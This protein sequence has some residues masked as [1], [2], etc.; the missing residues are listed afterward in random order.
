M[1]KVIAFKIEI[2]GHEDSRRKIETIR[3]ELDTAIQALTKFAAMSSEFETAAKR[4][5]VLE[6]AL[7]K[8]VDQLEEINKKSGAG[9]ALPK[10]GTT[11]SGAGRSSSG[12]GSRGGAGAKPPEPVP[13][14]TLKSYEDLVKKAA[15]LSKE[16]DQATEELRILTRAAK[17]QGD[18]SVE[19]YD[20]VIKRIA[21]LKQDQK[22]TTAEIRK[23]QRAI[24]EAGFASG[25]YRALNAELGRLRAAYRDMG[26]EA[27]KSIGGK[28]QLSRIQDLDGQLKKIDKSL[29]ITV[30][31][32]GNYRDAIRGLNNVI[33][34]FA[35]F[36]IFGV[37]AREIVEA[38]AKISDSLA[39]VRKTTGLSREEL[40]GY[41][42]AV[43]S[44]SDTL[45][46]L[47]TRTSL[48]DLL[49][50]SR[51]GGQ[52]GI[53]KEAVQLFK[54]LRDAGDEAGAALAL[55]DAEAQ[56][57]SF[58]KAI[59]TVVVALGDELGGDVENIAGDFG[60]LT[61]VLGVTDEFSGDTAQGILAISSAVN[62]LGASGAAQAGPII[63]FAK[64]LGG[65]APQANI[66]A[67][68][69]L[70]LAA[71][72]DELGISP[73]TASTALSAFLVQIGQ[74]VPRFAAIAGLS[75]EEFSEK[76][77]KDGSEG[78][79]SVLEGAQSTGGGLEELSSILGDLG[80]DNA[81]ATQV[82]G[83]LANNLD[84]VRD[85]QAAA[86]DQF[87]IAKG[88]IAGTL[89]V[90]EEFN[91]KNQTLGAELEKLKNSFTN[92]ITGS[93]FQD[94]LAG[95]IKALVGFVNALG[96]IPGFL[97]EN[98]ALI[99]GLAAALV[100]LNAANIAAAA[101][102][103][104]AAAATKAKAV[105]DKAATASTWLLNAAL[106]ANP[107]GLVVAAIALLVGGLVWAYQ[108]FDSV[109][110]SV[111]NAWDSLIEFTQGTGF[112]NKAVSVLTI[113]LRTA[114]F[115]VQNF[116]S[117][118]AG[119]K[120]AAEQAIGNISANFKLLII[121]AEL[122][123]LAIKN[124]FTFDDNAEALIEGQR[125]ALQK[126]RKTVESEIKPVAAAFAQAYTDAQ[127]LAT[128]AALKEEKAA[129]ESRAKE[130]AGEATKRVEGETEAEKAAQE[131]AGAEA[132]KKRKERAEAESKERKKEIEQE[133]KDKADAAKRIRG[134]EAELLTD[135]T[136][137]K[138]AVAVNTSADEIRDLVGDPEQITRQ[139]ALIQGKL[140]QAINDI[141]ETRRE[142]IL[143]KAGE[144]LDQVGSSGLLLSPEEIELE[145][146]AIREK[147]KEETETLFADQEARLRAAA[148]S[149]I[150]GL[151][152]TP[153]NI[154]SQAVAIRAQL[155]EDLA[156][157]EEERA[158]FGELS[159][160]AEEERQVKLREIQLGALDRQ[161]QA[162]KVKRESDLAKRLEEIA[163]E[164]EAE[165]LTRDEIA[166]RIKEAED[167]LREKELED[168]IDFQNKKAEIIEGLAD[169]TIALAEEI[170]AR[171]LDVARD[172]NKKLLESE[173][174]RAK[175]AAALQK[176][177]LD[178]LSGFVSGVKDLLSKDEATRKKYG[179]ALKALSLAEVAINLVTEIQAINKVNTKYG[180]P[181]DTIIKV[182]TIGKAVISAGVAVAKINAQEFGEGGELGL[183]RRR[184]KRS[185]AK[186][187]TEESDP[188]SETYRKARALIAPELTSGPLV[189]EIDSPPVIPAKINA[190]E[191]IARPMYKEATNSVDALLAAS[192]AS[193]GLEGYRPP[194]S[195]FVVGS[196]YVP[197]EGL[198]VGPGHD[199]GGVRVVNEFGDLLELEGG[200][201]VLRN[202]SEVYVM[203]RR[204]S[205]RYRSELWALTKGSAT[206]SIQ[207]RELASKIN[208]V[209]GWGRQFSGGGDLGQIYQDGGVASGSFGG[210]SALA[211]TLL[212]PPEI[213]LSG[214]D[215]GSEELLEEVRS[216]NQN[217]V[218]LIGLQDAKLEELRRQVINL[219]VNFSARDLVE[220]GLDEIAQEEQETDGF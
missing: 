117:V 7:Q 220:T 172:K 196:G 143:E 5:Q 169:E 57:E 179:A 11:E 132:A 129:Q 86:S 170:A 53:G 92:L 50:I 146:E 101:S 55:E 23:Q 181:F 72:I 94:F 124:A 177:Q 174:A 2:N 201:F 125:A 160:Q 213:D 14:K 149:N 199:S 158:A 33:A 135:E 24:E 105:A 75:V 187:R 98:R 49:D 30:R 64:R 109:R 107:I 67:P 140:S 3:S 219:K 58:T 175:G 42:D 205:A 173:E 97:V 141:F 133:I 157:I 54:D 89:S 168:E 37:G 163:L 195:L 59:D 87:K 164:A 39:D 78:L 188:V 82:L 115:V 22:E 145:G 216:Q 186:P 130:A 71:T 88:E 122:V 142:A 185:R 93:G 114:V 151:I 206:Y 108:N 44:L 209:D 190:R 128:E 189:V 126:V 15:E 34:G 161:A 91:V 139:T 17:T 18:T 66:S 63:D 153:K 35:A 51:I 127:R 99:I 68:S 62:T 112:L 167:E 178:L 194:G 137:R 28:E 56:L 6:T 102:T 100:T 191:A 217:L 214:G 96:S 159:A 8:V 73:E 9:I 43:L 81:R 4:V 210:G 113:G 38:N 208:S 162:A 1:A 166:E 84:V 80:V 154:E 85:R 211:T 79:L 25:S 120:A 70:G 212:A 32:V 60:K 52:L 36:S 156:A 69:L 152:G 19:G 123:R 26:E 183:G 207:R 12:L 21:Q 134:L 150:S 155:A 47:D 180:E 197:N 171:E 121:D 202:G 76:L 13:A 45:K 203:N 116:G 218:S 111:N 90:T 144:D 119:V 16:T 198:V 83:G 204:S 110:E 118:W 77:K 192:P 131:K 48:A 31:N 182:A 41:D 46:A 61:E 74:D 103:L 138:V 20:K 165:Q 40:E 104:Y 176:V 200:E 148:E 10:S 106:N 193:Q 65:L 184:L 95:G 27:R 147:V 215:Q 136:D 29:G